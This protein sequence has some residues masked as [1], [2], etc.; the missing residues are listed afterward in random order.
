MRLVAEASNGREAIEQFRSHRP[1]VTLMDLQMPERKI[2]VGALCSGPAVCQPVCKLHISS[3]HAAL[4]AFFRAV[5]A[6][7]AI[8]TSVA[9]VRASA[10]CGETSCQNFVLTIT[11]SDI[12]K[13]MARIP[14]LSMNE[15]YL[16]WFG[17][18]VDAWRV[19]R[20]R[21]SVKARR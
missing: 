10:G 14:R 13:K 1:D 20:L 11:A 3:T 8:L 2:S 19:G 15:T 17:E 7:L 9:R 5:P 4:S 21:H 18:L 16:L 6:I 12:V